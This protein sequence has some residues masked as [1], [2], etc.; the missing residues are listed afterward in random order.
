[1]KILHVST[2]ITNLART[3]SRD[4]PYCK[5]MPP[6]DVIEYL[7]EESGRLFDP[8][9]VEKFLALIDIK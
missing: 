7:Q 1:M 2:P 4:R 8:D 6:K 9:I 5:R 3:V